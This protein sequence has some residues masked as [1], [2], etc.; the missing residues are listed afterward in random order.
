MPRQCKV[1]FVED[2][3][4]TENERRRFMEEMYK[5]EPR[6]FLDTDEADRLI[7]ERRR[8]LLTAAEEA[9]DPVD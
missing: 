6:I 7:D 9:D 3:D 1:A 2:T 5:Q 4:L 8:R